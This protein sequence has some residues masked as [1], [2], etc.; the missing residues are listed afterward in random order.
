MRTAVLQRHRDDDVAG[1]LE[2][3]LE[4]AQQETVVQGRVGLTRELWRS[5][6]R[7][8]AE[9]LR[10]RLPVAVSNDEPALRGRARL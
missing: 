8:E 5:R 6:S 7:H 4:R 10:G 1:D 9:E 2:V 3:D